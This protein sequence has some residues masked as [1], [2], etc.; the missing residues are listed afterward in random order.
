MSFKFYLKDKVAIT[1]SGEIGHVIS[2]SEHLRA[3]SQYRIEYKTADGR[4]GD[5]WLD[6]DSLTLVSAAE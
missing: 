1:V 5:G 3:Q 6:E 2:R 4:A